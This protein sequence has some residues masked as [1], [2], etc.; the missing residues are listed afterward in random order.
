V[1]G[2]EGYGFVDLGILVP[3][4]LLLVV[5]VVEGLL[6]VHPALSESDEQVR[7]LAPLHT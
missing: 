6:Q 5:Q 1:A 4:A 7:Q 2:L 3:E